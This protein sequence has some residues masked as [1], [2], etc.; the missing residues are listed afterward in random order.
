[1]KF[2]EFEESFV[3]WLKDYAG[4]RFVLDVG[5]GEGHL[6]EALLLAGV[7]TYGV[8]IQEVVPEERRER[9]LE[10]PSAFLVG[11]HIGDITSNA[12]RKILEQ[13]RGRSVVM[14]A[15]P[16]HGSFIETVGKWCGQILYVGRPSYVEDDTY[17]AS[18]RLLLNAPGLIP[19]DGEPIEAWE[20]N[21]ENAR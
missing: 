8:D 15:R 14:F 9:M 10:F 17:G 19:L 12:W 21:Y 1:M 16:C 5:C 11:A 7:T 2:I 4:D 13:G 6:T 20:I 18:S 3:A